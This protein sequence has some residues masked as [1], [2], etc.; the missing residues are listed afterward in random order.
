VQVDSKDVDAGKPF[1]GFNEQ[2][3]GGEKKWVLFSEP[4]QGQKVRLR[5]ISWNTNHISLRLGLLVDKA[6]AEQL[7]PKEQP[8]P[9]RETLLKMAEDWEKALK[10]IKTKIAANKERQQNGNFD[11]GDPDD[12]FGQGKRLQQEYA[13]LM[14]DKPPDVDAAYDKE[15]QEQQATEAQRVSAL[16]RKEREWELQNPR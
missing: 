15:V 8:K 14:K 9:S 2:P 6:T 1:E 13:R 3:S 10:A 7:T 16:K 5:P 4:V 12:I 11:G